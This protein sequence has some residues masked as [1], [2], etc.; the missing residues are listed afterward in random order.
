MAYLAR[1]GYVYAVI[2][3]DS[4]M[5]AYQ[6]PRILFK[7]N[8]NTGYGQELQYSKLLDSPNKDLNLMS[9]TPR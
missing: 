9:F 5:I 2:T 7:L 6:C 3:E 1:S 4:D 8:T